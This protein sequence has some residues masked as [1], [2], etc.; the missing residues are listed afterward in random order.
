MNKKDDHDY[1]CIP[2]QA[3]SQNF[4]LGGGEK[5]EREGAEPEVICNLYL[6]LRLL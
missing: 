3:C 5:Q 6:I 4:G 2:E 1:N